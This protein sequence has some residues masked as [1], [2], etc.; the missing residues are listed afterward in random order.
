MF[1]MS[2]LGMFVLDMFNGLK[3]T[4]LEA[5]RVVEEH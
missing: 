3:L 1:M 2:R 4:C 5:Q